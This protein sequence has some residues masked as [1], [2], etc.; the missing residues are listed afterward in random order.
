[1]RKR[2]RRLMMGL[3]TL[4]GRPRGFFSPYRYA[5]GVDAPRGYPELEAI[6][7]LARPAIEETLGWIA[8]DAAVLD[9]FNGPAP[10]PR[11][12]QVWFTAFDGAST[13]AI[14]RRLRPGRV[15][16]VG[17]G[18][19]TRFMAAALEGRPTIIHCIDPQPRAQLSELPVTWQNRLLSEA[20][21]AEFRTLA[22]GDIAFFD[23]SHLLWPG[24]DVD[25]QLNRIL[26]VLAPGV[27]VH[28]HDIFLPDPYPREWDWRGY[29]EQLGLGGWLAGG[30]YRIR[31]ASHYAA[32]RLGAAERF[33]AHAF[34]GGGG[35]LWLER[36]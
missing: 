16:E 19:S 29:T 20:N 23:S 4:A 5:A 3:S 25:L 8:E 9:A 21:I 31:F 15:I 2:L 14:L 11:W 27:W 10:L 6:F 24:S 17:S 32:T 34:A 1:M 30:A 35:S 28:I 36:V 33:A 26:P 13:Y 12:D 18:H 22:P 7:D